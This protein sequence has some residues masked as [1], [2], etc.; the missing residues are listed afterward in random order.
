MKQDSPD[1]YDPAN[2]AGKDINFEEMNKTYFP[3]LC[4]YAK[5]YVN[6]YA[7]DVVQNLFAKMWEKRN[8]FHITGKLSTYLY[9]SVYNLCVN[10]LFEKKV[11]SNY[12]VFFPSVHDKGD[13]LQA[14]EY[15]DLLS[16]MISQ[17]TVTKIEN[18]INSLPGQ[19]RKIVLLWLEE[20]KYQEIAGILEISIN[21]VR[22]QITRAKKTIR[23]SIVNK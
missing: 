12:I 8:T 14:S 23:K 9:C 7:E 17:E 3:P 4:R 1:K 19:Q 10:H 6:H 5:R 11:L 20:M 22:T 15:S 13:W 2:I 18:E 16:M 21:T